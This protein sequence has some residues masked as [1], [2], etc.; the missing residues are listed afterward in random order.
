MAGGQ[1]SSRAPRCGSRLDCRNVDKTHA[2]IERSKS[3]PLEICIEAFG[4]DYYT[5]EAFLLAAPHIGR[6]KYLS[7]LAGDLPDIIHYFFRRAPLLEELNIN[8]YARPFPVLSGAFLDGNLTSLRKLSLTGVITHIPWKN[9]SNLT[10]FYLCDIP[11]DRISVTQLLNFFENA[12]LHT[13]ELK[14]S[15]PDS[16][17]ASPERIVSLSSLRKL[18]I[19]AQPT[20]STLINR[21]SIPIGASL[22]LDFNFSG[23]AIPILDYLPKPSENVKTL[24]RVTTVNLLL[25]VAVK[26]LRLGGPNG[27]TR[28]YCRRTSSRTIPSL[29]VDSR[30]LH[31]LDRSILSTTKWLAISKSELPVRQIKECQIFWTLF[32]MDDLRTPHIDSMCQL[33]IHFRPEPR[34]KLLKPC[35]M[36]QVGRSR[37]LRLEPRQDRYHRHVEHGEGA[38]C[39]RREALVNHDHWSQCIGAGTRGGVQTHGPCRTCGLQGR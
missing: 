12:S 29:V 8:L 13:I 4:H 34:P 18:A 39:E 22:V 9:L 20:H 5:K 32:R 15:I 28:V 33:T 38:S 36:S 26:F 30:I 1:F 27:E 10:T 37:A 3:A 23:D 11:E 19:T 17:D 7:I 25:S 14:R 21:L 16:S 31:S 2:Y 35:Y 6:L 24:S